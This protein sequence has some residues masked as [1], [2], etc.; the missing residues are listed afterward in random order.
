MAAD[1]NL[2]EAELELIAAEGRD[3]KARIGTPGERL[4][5]QSP[6]YGGDKLDAAL[7]DAVLGAS[8]S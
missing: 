1:G 4:A 7:T 3:A 5:A 6:D 2:T 8:G